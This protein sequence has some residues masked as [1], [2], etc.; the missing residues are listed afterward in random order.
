MNITTYQSTKNEKSVIMLSITF[1][2]FRLQTSTGISI[3]K[4]H[5]DKR[6]IISNKDNQFEF[7]RQRIDILK[8]NILRFYNEYE[9]TNGINTMTPALLKAKL[10][11]WKP[12]IKET[13]AANL[14]S[15]TPDLLETFDSFIENIRSGIL[16]NKK[17]LQY[18][19]QSIRLFTFTSKILAKFKKETKFNLTFD[20]IDNNFKSHF[21]QFCINQNLSN[22]SIANYLRIF[23]IFMQYAFNQKIHTNENFK[24]LKF[25]TNETDLIAL[26][27]NEILQ[28]IEY[29][30]KLD[31][32][33]NSKLLFLT[34]FYTGQRY[35]DLKNINKNNIDYSKGIIKFNSQKTSNNI[36]IPITPGLKKLLPDFLN[37][38]I[39]DITRQ[40]IV[41]KE[42]FK[43][44]GI[45]EIVNINQ[46]RAAKK[47]IVSK[48]KYEVI[49]THTARRSF[50]TIALK[51]GISPQIIMK[52][53]G[54]KDFKSFEKYIKFSETD[55]IEIFQSIK[56]IE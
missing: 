13:A 21:L 28:L 23:K 50:I 52:V 45:N 27:E 35:S 34:Q 37:A 26:T 5:F 10:K 31:K 46:V 56:L 16:L 12:T 55:I 43:E 29:K 4:N 41:L 33:K 40:N 44:I 1:N 32:F 38:K 15:N 19:N 7:K 22:N 48:P 9:A 14:Q 6:N 53:T 51:K 49:G 17:D 18:S 11:E 24:E 20:S 54:H 30:P 42:L 25:T 3:L 2:G 47:I 39:L 36:I 8:A